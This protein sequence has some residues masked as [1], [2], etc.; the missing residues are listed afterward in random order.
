MVVVPP[1]TPVTT[2]EDDTEPTAGVVLD[3]VPPLGPLASAEVSPV[4]TFNPPVIGDKALTLTLKVLLQ[5]V[6]NV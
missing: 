2:P 1:E 5:P 3:H 6:L 4:H